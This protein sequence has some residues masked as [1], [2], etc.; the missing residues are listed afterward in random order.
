MAKTHDV[1]SFY[2]HTMVYPVKPP[3]LFEKAETQE[4][5]EPY[6]FGKGYC[7]RAPFTR[8]SLVLG[9]W[10]RRYSESEA[11]TVAINGRAMTKD[12]VDWDYIRFGAEHDS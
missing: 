10:V 4:I 5:E 6:R 3:V 9:K 1:G 11:L 8:V 2:W 12:E 7:I